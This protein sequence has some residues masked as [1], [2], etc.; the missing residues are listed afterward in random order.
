M[1]KEQLLFDLSQSRAV[2]AR[3]C[4]T[5]RQELDFRAK[6]NRLVRR[7]PLAWL[8]GAAALGWILAGPKTKTRVVK[9]TV[10]ASGRT[11]RSKG[12]KPASRLGWLA[13][14]LALIKFSAPLLKPALTAYAGKR[15]ANM[16]VNLVK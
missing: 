9:K 10:T 5:V 15:F 7:K 12:T 14:L 1:T 4:A 11:V 2:L 6:V 8:G 13:T 16:A 3:D